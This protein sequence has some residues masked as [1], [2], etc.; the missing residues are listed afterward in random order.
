[1]VEI[2]EDPIVAESLVRQVKAHRHGAIVT[3]TGV[4]R[5][6]SEGRRVLHLEYEAYKE[7]ATQKLEEIV[8]EAQSRWLG[9]DMA[10]AHRVGRLSVGET[11]LIIAVAAPHRAEAFAACQYAVDRLKEVVPIWKKEVWEGGEGWIGYHP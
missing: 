9:I 11:S 8:A 10:L 2:T 1:M 5:E 3:F 6:E 4:V 7:M